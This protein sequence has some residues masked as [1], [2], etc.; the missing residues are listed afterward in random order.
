MLKHPV[1][2]LDMDGVLI[3]RTDEILQEVNKLYGTG[4]T[5]N[6]VVDFNYL[7]MPVEHRNTVYDLW[8]SH[9]DSGA[10][11][12][13]LDPGVDELIAGL[14]ELGRVIVCSSPMPESIE[15]KYDLL[16]QHFEKTNITFMADKSLLRADVLIDDGPHN[17][18]AF[19]GYGIIFDRPWN[20]GCNARRAR[21]LEEVGPIVTDYLYTEGYID[22]ENL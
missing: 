20:K 16:L 11:V 10:Y 8:D 9:Y 18:K 5:Y 1:I 3:D 13:F 4:Y 19:P 22:L 6:D 21:S 12:D 17:I 15:S 14:Q 7:F 2:A